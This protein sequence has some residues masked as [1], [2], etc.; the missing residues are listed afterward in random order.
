MRSERPESAG[1]TPVR[2]FPFARHRMDTALKRRPRRAGSTV[3]FQ[4]QGY[5][6]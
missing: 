2:A 3:L 1:T 6:R 4:W 5:D